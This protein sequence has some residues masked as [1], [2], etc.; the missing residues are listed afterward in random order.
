[1]CR[2]RGFFTFNLSYH[3]CTSCQPPISIS[4]IWVQQLYDILH[5]NFIDPDPGIVPSLRCFSLS[6]MSSA[7][8]HNLPGVA[9]IFHHLFLRDESNLSLASVGILTIVGQCFVVSDSNFIFYVWPCGISDMSFI[10]TFAAFIGV[11]KTPTA[12]FLS[13]S[14]CAND[15]ICFSS[16]A[17]VS[18]IALPCST[19][20]PT[21]S[22]ITP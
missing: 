3:C 14:S 7:A 6:P 2:K 18:F 10:P 17:S 1:M 22:N 4:I 5:W 13:S 11:A 8:Y 9:W 20:A 19:A 15:G 16:L 12:L 21:P